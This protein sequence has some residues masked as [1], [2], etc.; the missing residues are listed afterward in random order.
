MNFYKTLERIITLI[1]I[2]LQLITYMTENHL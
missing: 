1:D 2:I